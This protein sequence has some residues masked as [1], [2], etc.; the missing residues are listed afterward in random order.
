MG[1]NVEN[2]ENKQVVEF[3]G[4]IYEEIMSVIYRFYDKTLK[5]L[6]NR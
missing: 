3:V 1:K 2:I 6:V 5:D 4:E